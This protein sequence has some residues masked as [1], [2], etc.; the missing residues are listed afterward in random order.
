MFLL[1]L[2][3]RLILLRAVSIYPRFLGRPRLLTRLSSLSVLNFLYA[4]VCQSY[5]QG[6]FCHGFAN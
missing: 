1:P 5:A 4:P 6:R 2:I 3:Y